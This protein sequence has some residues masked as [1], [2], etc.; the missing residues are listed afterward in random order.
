MSFFWMIVALKI[1]SELRVSDVDIA[2]F[3]SA[4][5][6]DLVDLFDVLSEHLIFFMNSLITNLLW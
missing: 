6:Q 2:P 1:V 4:G 5:H 3:H